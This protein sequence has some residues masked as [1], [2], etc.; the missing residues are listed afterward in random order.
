MKKQILILLLIPFIS[1]AQCKW[2]QKV[3]YKMQIKL[4]PET[5]QYTGK[6]NLT[7]INNSPDELNKI[8][9]HLYYNAFQPHSLMDERLK[10]IKD[11]DRRMMTSQNSG[12]TVS[13]ISQMSPKDIG[14]Q[15]IES[16]VQNGKSLSF[17]VMGTLL[18]VDLAKPI[19]AET[20]GSIEIK[21]TAQVPEMVRRG[22][23]NS[24]EKIDFSM[25]QWYPKVAMYNQQGWHLDEYIGREFFAPFG[26]FDVQITLPSTYIVGA[27]GR[28]QNE[29]NMPGYSPKKAKLGTN[30]T[31]HFIAKDIHDFVWAADT[32]YTV[33]KQSIKH[34]PTLY[35]L[36]SKTLSKEA[37]ENWLKLQSYMPEYY[38][39]MA[40]RFGKY[41]W[42]TYSIIQGGDGG[43]EYGAATLI[44]GDRG[45][46]SLVGVVFHEASHSWFQQLFGIDETQDEWFDEGFTS[47]A[48]AKVMAKAFEQKNPD[49]K[50]VHQ[51][52]YDG[53]Y[54]YVNSGLQEPLSILADYYNYNYAYGISAYY[55]GQIFVSQLGY[56]IGEDNLKTTFKLFYDEWKFRHPSPEDFIKIAQEVSG[57]NLKWYLNLFV[58]TTRVIDYQVSLLNDKE[59]V[60]ENLS[61]FAMPI[62]ALVT[63]EDGTQELFYIP[64]HAMR[65]GK[66]KETF[67]Y[68]NVTMTEL[69]DWG[70]TSPNYTIKVKNKVKSVEIDPTHRLADITLGNN[71]YPQ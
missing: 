60:I 4:T 64:L 62:D 18:E 45:L 25:S 41:P 10:N 16:I 22:G 20:S 67:F 15:E 51:S 6:M 47:Y 42:S 27:S 66:K 36:Y 39:F 5:H 29:K 68:P 61:N 24:P 58:N 63:Y 17:K 53:Y 59:I 50:F 31:W 28:L 8:Y 21:W 52:A 57:I 70:W 9:L 56:I 43:M 7:Y 12:E 35:Y 13:K 49:A 14:F 2:Q 1:I 48:E 40:S 30:L 44:K 3:D 32:N 34:G 54:S 38:A 19:K 26:D 37:Q 55:K 46:E 11:P 69:P 33:K 65:A 71:K 23:A